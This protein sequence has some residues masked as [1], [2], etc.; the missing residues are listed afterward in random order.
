MFKRWLFLLWVLVISSSVAAARELLQ[1]EECHVKPDETIQGTLFVLCRTLIIE[2][3]VT[4]NLIGGVIEA[5]ISGI[6][7]GNLYL[8]GGQVD[9]TGR[10]GGDLHYA[11]LVLNIFPQIA[12]DIPASIGGVVGG[13]LFNLSLTT[14]LASGTRLYGSILTLG[15]QL[16]IDGE[17]VGEVSFWGSALQIGGRISGNI[18]A[19][20]GDPQ[21]DSSQ[22]ETLLLPLPFDVSLTNP[23]LIVRSGGYVGGILQYTGPVAGQIDG[24]LSHPPDYTPII[25]NP[26]LPIDEPGAFSLYLQQVLQEFW[27]L[28]LIGLLILALSPNIIQAPSPNL[29]LRPLSTF[30]VGMLTFI[31][32]FPIILISSLLGLLVILMLAVLRLDALLG[33]ALVLVLI[34]NAGGAV[35]FYFLSIFISR[36]IVCLA[37]GRWLVRM[38]GRAGRQLRNSYLHYTVG[39][40]I[41]A[42]TATLPVVGWVINALALFLGLGALLIFMLEYGGRLR[43]SSARY[44]YSATGPSPYAR[45]Y[46]HMLERR[47]SVVD[48]NSLGMQNL[49]EGFDFSFFEED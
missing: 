13:D 12:E 25:I 42:I 41:L 22:L 20:V 28:L 6:I 35:L 47:T 14:H 40:L 48:E 23:G 17:A 7:N 45:D 38:L 18:Y 5:D 10:I 21:S 26:T 36:A 44:Q 27:S 9:V 19:T 2:G 24:E 46:P 3:R 32:S 15:Y 33:A 49:P 29:R 31:L 34:L 39:V 43:A 1:A 11:G 16:I 37:L 30:S 8:I 4:G